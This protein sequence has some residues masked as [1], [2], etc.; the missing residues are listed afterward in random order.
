MDVK[1]NWFPSI[2][3]NSDEPFLIAGYSFNPNE[4]GTHGKYLNRAKTGA[5]YD[6]TTRS[7]LPLVGQGTGVYVNDNA[8]NYWQGNAVAGVSLHGE[9][10]F[11]TAPAATRDTIANGSGVGTFH[12][13]YVLST[14]E[15]HVT[16]DSGTTYSITSHSCIG[17]GP[18]RCDAWHDGTSQRL[19]VN[20]VLADSDVAALSVPANTLRVGC[21]GTIRRAN[22]RSAPLGSDAAYRAL[23][24]RDFARVPLWQWM[25]Q[26]IGEGP[27]SGILTNSV[28]NDF[29]CPLGASTQQFVWLPQEKQLALYDTNVAAMNRIEFMH[30]EHPIFGSWLIEYKVTDPA[31][32]SLIIGFGNKRGIDPTTAGSQAYWLNMR[33]VAGPWFRASLYY[34]NG[35]QLDAV[36]CKYPGPSAGD[37]GKILLTHAVNGDWQIYNWVSRYKGWWY[38]SAVANDVTKLSTSTVVVSSRGCKVLGI[39]RYQGEMTPNELGIKL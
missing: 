23:Y 2:H 12:R 13:F 31:T 16:L 24:V 28:H 29:W 9:M 39:K 30:K 22:I 8:G 26:E 17:R 21:H 19:L 10:Q 35:A 6:L 15:V 1:Q 20:G 33:T 25:P 11:D 5:T 27:A 3:I 32:D 38:S 37:T 7:G 4:L 14:G 34:E 18:I 36:D